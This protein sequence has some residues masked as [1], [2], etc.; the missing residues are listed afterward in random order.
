MKKLT[1]VFDQKNNVAAIPNLLVRDS[2]RGS[3]GVKIAQHAHA[4]MKGKP[5]LVDWATDSEG[6]LVDPKLKP[7]VPFEII[8][9]FHL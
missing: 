8:A 7:L 6:A 4:H 3:V 9:G 5:Y 1:V 2:G